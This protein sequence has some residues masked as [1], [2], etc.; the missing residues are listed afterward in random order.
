MTQIE[1][2]TEEE[3]RR[4]YLVETFGP[5][6]LVGLGTDPPSR[7]TTAAKL[8]S[9]PLTAARDASRPRTRS[10]SPWPP[11]SRTRTRPWTPPYG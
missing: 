6:V 11:A 9:D 5:D 3:A 10:W 1:Q 2:Q 7:N 8:A 4:A